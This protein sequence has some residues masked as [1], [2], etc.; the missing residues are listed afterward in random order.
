MNKFLPIVIIVVAGLGLLAG[1]FFFLNKN[2]T[3]GTSIPQEKEEVFKEL[4]LTE[5][6]YVT[7]TPRVDG[8]EF[9][10]TIEK[11]P[12][13]AKIVEYELIYKNA[14]GVTQGVPGSIKFKGEKIIERDLLLGSCSS[15]KCKYDD[16]VEEGTFA[17]KL[18][19]DNGRLITK[20]ETGFHLQKN[21]AKL[22]SL[23][24]KFSLQLPDKNM[25][26]SYYL[27]MSTFGLPEK[28]EGVS[29]SPYGVFTK[30]KLSKSFKAEVDL[31]GVIYVYTTKWVKLDGKI[32]S[33]LGAFVST[34]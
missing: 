4:P 10:L 15:G 22:T 9:H 34:Q 5:R 29:T 26:T 2:N 25:M 6:P 17:L 14:D 3:V 28:K 13:S 19:D 18:R 32:S 30:A 11:V 27:T 16:G 21:E 23:D 7:L 12:T 33:L 8:H 24:Q 31:P 1:A 20:M